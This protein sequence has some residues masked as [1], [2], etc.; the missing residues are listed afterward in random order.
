[1]QSWLESLTASAQGSSGPALRTEADRQSDRSQSALLA[2]HHGSRY[3]SRSPDKHCAGSGER[4]LHATLG[5]THLGH[6]Q[7]EDALNDDHVSRLH[8]PRLLLPL[9][10]L[11]AVQAASGQLHPE[12]CSPCQYGLR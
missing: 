6:V 4:G 8:M 9:V 10:R 5:D 1:M 7:D 12:E 2:R 11:E 3:L